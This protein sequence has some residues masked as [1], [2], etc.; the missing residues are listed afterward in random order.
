EAVLAGGGREGQCAAREVERTGTFD[1]T[2]AGAA[3]RWPADPEPSCAGAGPRS[4]SGVPWRSAA[5]EEARRGPPRG[6]ADSPPWAAT[7]A[8]GYILRIEEAGPMTRRRRKGHPQTL[9]DQRPPADAVSYRPPA[10]RT[11]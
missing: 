11:S 5:L 9:V 10:A 6:L 7:P 8:P 3:A 1:A 4:R 2:S